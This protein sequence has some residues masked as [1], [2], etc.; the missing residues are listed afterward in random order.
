MKDTEHNHRENTKPESDSPEQNIGSL[1]DASA[2][3]S[4][5]ASTPI[6]SVG[7]LISKVYAGTFRRKNV[8][9]SVL[10]SM[11][12]KPD[13]SGDE[14]EKLV[15]QT[16][17][18]RLLKTTLDL[19]KLGGKIGS[20]KVSDEI[21]KFVLGKLKKHPAFKA[22]PLYSSV[23]NV[24]HFIA[25]P[26]NYESLRWLD[27]DYK[28]T[29]KELKECRNNALR[30]Y[31]LWVWMTKNVPSER[32]LDYL[33]KYIWKPAVQPSQ[34]EIEQV[35]LLTSARDH[36]AL[37]ISTEILHR[38]AADQKQR[39]D[40]AEIANEQ[41]LKRVMLLESKL[42][43][44]KTA[45]S[46]AQRKVDSL[47]KQLEKEH[48]DHANDSAH[49]KDDYESLRGQVLRRLNNELTLLEEGLQAIRRNPPKINVMID[50][51]ERA[52]DG[53]RNECKR[54]QKKG[55]S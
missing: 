27:D 13:L 30:C 49:L 9:K 46:D 40:S 55:D 53:L 50:H 29:G 34:A 31:L 28:L 21:G 11:R 51:A 18:D 33:L 39:A 35:I 5:S 14:I 20:S 32:V 48:Q 45:L 42:D 19:V 44:I 47:E 17:E 52:I 6:E 43:K 54:L 8:S 24:I 22:A 1:A 3:A 10:N 12:K 7:E 25:D 4:R 41:S 23:D 38:D 2:R 37:A 16:F 26:K 36:E 15:N